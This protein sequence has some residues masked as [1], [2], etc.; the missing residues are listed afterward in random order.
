MSLKAKTRAKFNQAKERHDAA[1]MAW[2]LNA[3]DRNKQEL[4]EATKALNKARKDAFM[5]WSSGDEPLI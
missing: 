1:Q 4:E 3:S 5:Y 2:N